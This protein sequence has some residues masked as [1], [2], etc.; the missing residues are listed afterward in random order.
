MIRTRYFST[1]VILTTDQ[2][3]IEQK[4]LKYSVCC[5]Y[6][7]LER[8]W[9]IFC[10]Q[11]V[12]IMGAGGPRSIF[13]FWLFLKNLFLAKVIEFSNLIHQNSYNYNLHYTHEL[14]TRF[15]E[16][17][18][19]RCQHY[20]N[21]AKHS[22]GYEQNKCPFIRFKDLVTRVGQKPSKMEW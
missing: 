15:P 6:L 17:Q 4:R 12:K 13:T 19:R 22:R 16:I 9:K 3:M 11:H 20:Y 2:S 10:K 14:Q 5:R 7:V 21:W 8:L 1:R 18:R